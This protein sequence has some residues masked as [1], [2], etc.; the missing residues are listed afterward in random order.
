MQEVLQHVSP[1]NSIIFSML[2]RGCGGGG[3]WRG[4]GWRGGGWRGGPRSLR[5]A[6]R[7]AQAMHG[8]WFNLPTRTVLQHLHIIQM[9]PVALMPQGAHAWRRSRL[10][11]STAALTPEG[12]HTLSLSCIMGSTCSVRSC[13]VHCRCEGLRPEVRVSS[14]CQPASHHCQE[15]CFQRRCH[16]WHRCAMGCAGRS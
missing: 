15:C 6:G 9:P 5:G 3:G 11:A 8:F 7:R 10:N 13:A 12:T 1:C 14:P 4:G 16:R 2:G